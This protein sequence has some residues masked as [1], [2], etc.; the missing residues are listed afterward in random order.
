MRN[1]QKPHGHMPPNAVEILKIHLFHLEV[2]HTFQN[3]TLGLGTTRR[4]NWRLEMPPLFNVFLSND[5]L[6]SPPRRRE[7]MALRSPS[8]FHVIKGV[9]RFIALREQHL[10]FS[11][12]EAVSDCPLGEKAI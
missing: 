6:R 1:N 7:A 2:C 11:F 3:E 4:R 12:D 10:H 5:F 8:S 9:S